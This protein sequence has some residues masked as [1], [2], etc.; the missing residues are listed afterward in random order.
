M[1][2]KIIRIMGFFFRMCF[3]DVHILTNSNVYRSSGSGVSNAG[4]R[5][6]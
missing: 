2:G 5:Y 3:I 1:A 6:H 4:E